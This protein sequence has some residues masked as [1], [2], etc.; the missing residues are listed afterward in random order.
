M[1]QSLLTLGQPPCCWSS[2]PAWLP[3]S[4]PPTSMDECFFNSLVVR[5]PHNFWHSWLFI[6]FK[7]VI[8]LLVVQG[9]EAFVP[10]PPSWP[11]IPR[12]NFLKIHCCCIFLEILTLA[13]CFQHLFHGYF[14]GSYFY[15]HRIWQDLLKTDIEY[16]TLQDKRKVF[17]F[18]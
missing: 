18:L 11:E 7:F 17:I 6:V 10:M 13:F 9:S 2:P 1:S 4:T 3:I 15:V 16:Y 12:I 5:V 8:V 14:L